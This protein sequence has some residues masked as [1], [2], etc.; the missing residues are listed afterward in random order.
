MVQTWKCYFWMP[1]S[2]LTWSAS[3]DKGVEGLWWSFS[4]FLLADSYGRGWVQAGA[5][6]K[7]DPSTVELQL[8]QFDWQIR[9]DGQPQRYEST[10]Y[11]R[12]WRRV[13]RVR[14][15]RSSLIYGVQIL[16]VLVVWN[17][18]NQKIWNFW[19]NWNFGHMEICYMTMMVG[20]C[21]NK[22]FVAFFF[23]LFI[24]RLVLAIC[25]LEFYQENRILC[26]S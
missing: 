21:C 24:D 17:S 25:L 11:L 3:Q 8:L 2:S 10:I 18:C 12:V 23:K 13:L 4:T 19:S 7:W 20:S 5:L 22:G 1:L 14:V 16:L 26:P 9:I 15:T 6:R